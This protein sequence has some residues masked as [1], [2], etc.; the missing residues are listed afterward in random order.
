MNKKSTTFRRLLEAGPVLATVAVG[1][2]HQAQ[3]AQKAGCEAIFISG[4]LTS[5]HLLGLPDAG[6]LTLSEMVQN[7]ERICQAVDIPVYVDCDTGFG[8]AINVRRT[9]ESI[10]RAGAAGLFI[11]DQAAPKRCGF[12]KGKEV[13]PTAEAAGKYRAAA[14][15]RDELDPDFVLIARTDARGAVGGSLEQVVERGKAYLAAGVDMVYAEALQSREEVRYVRERLPACLFMITG[16]AIQPPLSDAEMKALGLSL[17]LS[18]PSKAA[19]V[20]L[21][22]FLTDFRARGQEAVAELAEK[23]KD[24]PLGGFGTF[25]LAGFPQVQE[26]ERKY[27]PPEKIEAY[28]KSLGLYDPRVGN[29][30]GNPPRQK[31]NA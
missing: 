18:F 24:H 15:V 1:T 21:Y 27:L 30:G 20:A 8:N 19:T 5:T 6:L 2:A 11:E 31:K 10:I 17:S 9:V 7:A 22:D 25:D 3:L 28:D 14:D 13:I 4:S 23:T 29:Q 16:I 26:W 12:V